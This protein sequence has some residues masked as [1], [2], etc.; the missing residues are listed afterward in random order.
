[1]CVSVINAIRAILQRCSLIAWEQLS[2]LAISHYSVLILWTIKNLKVCSHIIRS[3]IIQ[4]AA[5]NRANICKTTTLRK[6]GWIISSI[7]LFTNITCCNIIYIIST[8]FIKENIEIATLNPI[9]IL[10][11]INFRRSLQNVWK[12][13]INLT[14]ISTIHIKQSTGLKWAIINEDSSCYIR[15]IFS[16][17]CYARA[18]ISKTHCISTQIACQIIYISITD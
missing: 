17:K 15:I 12:I 4:T 16:D 14:Y 5:I 18:Q 9:G 11:A 13:I 8:I 3:A 7:I 6:A 10:N 1:M 2:E